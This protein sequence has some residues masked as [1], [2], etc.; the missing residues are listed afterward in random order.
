MC[1][2]W[3]SVDPS[4]T[5]RVDSSEVQIG[6]SGR[7]QL[8]QINERGQVSSQ[9]VAEQETKKFINQQRAIGRDHCRQGAKPREVEQK[10]GG[11]WQE[12]REEVGMVEEEG[13][14]IYVKSRLGE[15]ECDKDY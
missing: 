10:T 7:S 3:L 4:S 6:I 14:A 8:L 13:V 12:R 15:T 11:P 2:F 5:I 1:R 9:G